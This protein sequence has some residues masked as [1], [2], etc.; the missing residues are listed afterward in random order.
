MTNEEIFGNLLK[1]SKV[2]KSRRLKV[3]DH[4]NRHAE[5]VKGIRENVM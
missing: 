5:E 2:I 1:I 4:R 3:V